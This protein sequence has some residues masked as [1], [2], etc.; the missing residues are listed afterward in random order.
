MDLPARGVLDVD[1]FRFPR[2]L[3]LLLLIAIGVVATAPGLA[4]TVGT[5]GM[6]VGLA[7][8]G[9]VTLLRSRDLDPSERR[10]WQLLAAG[11]FLTGTGVFVVAAWH[12][13]IGPLPAFGPT[14]IF[15]VGGYALLIA[16]L[17]SLA[18]L[19]ADGANWTTTLL[20]GLV[21]GVALAALVWT[22]FFHD[23]MMGFRAAEWWEPL[24]GFLYPVL[25]VAVVVA[26]IVLVI[27]RS[28]FHFDMR[29]VFL[30]MAMAVQVLADFVF[31][32]SGVG[33]SFAEAQPAWPLNLLATTLLLITASLVNK[34]PSKREFP[35][36]DA[37]VWALLWPYLLAGALLVTHVVRY[38]SA[39]DSGGDTI[40]LDALLLI[41]VI[42]VRQVY[43][44]RRN[45]RRVDQQRSELVASVSHELRTPLTA[46]VGYLTLLDDNGDDFPQEARREMI[47]EATSQ[48]RHMARLVNDLVMLARGTMQGLPLAI[49]AVRISDIVSVSLQDID[50]GTTRV[51][52]EIDQEAVVN[53]DAD[54]VRQLLVNLL[55]NAVRYGGTQVKLLVLTGE[56][57][58]IEVHDDGAGVPTRYQEK[59]WDKFERGAHRL[60]AS[61]PGLGIGL[62]VVKAVA[63]SHGGSATYRDSELLGGACFS[64]LIPGCVAV[65]PTL[66]RV[67][68]PS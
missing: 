23:L 4:E 47:S 33:R 16:T 60:D 67:G 61:S 57:L 14:D 50:S 29:L 56:D 9:S 66:Q 8:A 28:H 62:S 15:F 35:E 12:V 46:M 3:I 37:P 64:V 27:R 20:D 26:V 24:I 68:V 59:I 52:A 43:K 58:L 10:A 31:F 54:R 30:G 1:F 2:P 32:S 25:D 5:V 13:A 36:R 11:L 6:V 49:S 45:Q 42:I 34:T 63:E 53:I 39:T 19:D 7:S 41:V 38:R 18:R 55:S 21:G 65:R 51:E 48:A 17:V 22:A 40:L 44:I